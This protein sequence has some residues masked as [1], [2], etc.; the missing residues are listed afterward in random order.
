MMVS[1][2]SAP[3]SNLTVPGP[4]PRNSWGRWKNLLRFGSNSVGYTQELFQTYGAICSLQYGGGTNLYSPLPDCPGTVFAYGPEFVKQV[5]TQHDV[6]HKHPL[7]GRLYRRR[8]ESGRTEPLKHFV[9]GLFGV[10]G[11]RHKQQRQLMMPAF[12][13]QQIE[14]YR[15]DI[16][17]ITE[18]VLENLSAQGSENS[19][20]IAQVMR[21]VTLRIATKTLFGEDMGD[22]GNS[23]GKLLQDV[24]TVMGSPMMMLFAYDIPGL[25]YHQFLSQIAAIDDRM[26]EL[27]SQKRAA[28]NTDRDV[29][30]ML[31][32]ARDETDGTGLSEDELL[33]HAGV[34]FAAGHETSANALIWT[35]FLLSQHPQIAAD[36]HDELT[37]VLHGEAPTVAQLAE[38]PLLER[39]IKESMRVLPPVP[40]NGRVTSQPTELGGYML[41]T[42]TEVFISFHQTHQM[43][44]LYPEPE[45]FNPQR[46]ETISPS[47]YEYCPFSAGSRVCIGAGFAMMEIKIVLALLL[48]RYRLQFIPQVT[49]DQTGVIVMSPRRGMPMQVH[50]Q[51]RAWGRGVGGVRGNV[52]DLVKLPE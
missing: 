17:S 40:W 44:E 5:A 42:G 7:T 27:I 36:L 14:S 24:L 22:R 37:T 52:R 10:N 2:V 33:G 15:D 9:V 6:Y 43:P 49:V 20:D 29:L 28:G 31:I 46:W 38:L 34:M 18:S 23:T 50:P 1:T 30:A 19:C 47:I 12:H 21:L 11:D 26:R 39:V 41:P 51:D 3:S 4:T 48:Q 35:L 45:V 25:P 16:V 13:R 32:Q 8:D